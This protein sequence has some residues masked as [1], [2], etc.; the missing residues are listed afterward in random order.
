[1]LR[2]YET[3]GT[4]YN[5]DDPPLNSC[6]LP[7]HCYYFKP[8]SI[9]GKLRVLLIYIHIH[10]HLYKCICSRVYIPG[11]PPSHTGDTFGQIPPI[12]VSRLVS[13]KLLAKLQFLKLSFFFFTFYKI[14][15]PERFLI[16]IFNILHFFSVYFVQIR[17]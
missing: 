15:L 6:L 9:L 8:E 13:R 4:W 17:K 10:L 14:Y 3:P 12:I 1:M 5:A 7:P 11:I 2:A 16:E